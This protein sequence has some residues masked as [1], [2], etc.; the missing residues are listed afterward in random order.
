MTAT[1]YGP[2]SV[3]PTLRTR[4]L[5]RATDRRVRKRH[6]QRNVVASGACFTDIK[7]APRARGLALDP[8]STT[9]TGRIYTRCSRAVADTRTYGRRCPCSASAV[10]DPPTPIASRLPPRIYC[11]GRLSPAD[12]PSVHANVYI[13]R[14]RNAPLRPYSAPPSFLR[15]DDSQ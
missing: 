13:S 10:N 1:K 11:V 8:L 14:R 3:G 15:A 6:T 7:H 2:R 4:P 5:P 12:R 9:P